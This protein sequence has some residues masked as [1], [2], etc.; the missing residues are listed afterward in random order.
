MTR[1]SRSP[2]VPC[3]PRNLCGVR[4]ITTMPS[5]SVRGVAWLAQWS[6]IIR[7]WSRDSRMG[8]LQFSHI[9]RMHIAKVRTAAKIVLTSSAQ[10]VLSRLCRRHRPNRT[11]GVS[12]CR[13]VL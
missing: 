10:P 13:H 7:P 1:S 5:S 9:I 3:T 4:F 11:H 6:Q 12:Q 8:A 2:V